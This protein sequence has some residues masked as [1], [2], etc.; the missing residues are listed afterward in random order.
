M[1]VRISSGRPCCSLGMRFAHRSLVVVAVL[2]LVAA[3]C[4]S[5]T[6]AETDEPATSTA[7]SQEPAS[8]DTAA[9]D[10]APGGTGADDLTFTLADGYVA[11]SIGEGVK[12]D[13]A[14]GPDGTAGIAYLVEDLN[15]FVAY[16]AAASEWTSERIID[17]YFYGPIGL[18]YDSDGV[19]NIAY[20]DHQ[21]ST[22]DEEKGDLTI[23]TR[24]DSTWMIEAIIGEGHDGWDSTI[25]IGADGVV[26]AAGIDPEQF[27]RTQGVEYY[28]LSGDAWEITE[29]GSGPVAYEFNVSLAVD[30]GGNPALT[31]YDTTNADLKYAVRDNGGWSIETVDAEG[32]V[33]RYSSL[34]FTSDGTPHI[35]YLRLDQSTAGTVR[36]AT[37][38][39]DGWTAVDIDTLADLRTGFT[40]ARRVTA[41]AVGPD[42]QPQIVYS[43][44]SVVKRAVADGGEWKAATLI[45]ADDRALGQLVSFALSTDGTM[46]LAIFEVT[47]ASP[48]SGI[49]AYVTTR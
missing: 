38:D 32:D 17:G 19:P 22:F 43:D 2:G 14:L 7:S 1:T 48:L 8:T 44:E 3:A 33:G 47:S 11:I 24:Q 18:A 45:T 40:G 28:E 36:Y 9:D 13:L 41:I 34:A 15:G 31:Y 37:R 16:A 27:G 6:D 26:R 39:G 30:P 12:P 20:H 10:G 21:D 4:S 46:H 49:V 29:I 42:Q 5:D 25:A 23:A 35:S